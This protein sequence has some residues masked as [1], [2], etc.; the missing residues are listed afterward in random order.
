MDESRVKNADIHIRV[1]PGEKT[2]LQ[3]NAK[4]TGKTL[5][6]YLKNT[7]LEP[8]IDTAKANFY[9]SINADLV[10]LKRATVVLTK[11]TLLAVNSLYQD[12]KELQKE[13]RKAV[14]E[15]EKIFK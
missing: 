11:L 3:I 8:N 15:A 1:T 14:D 6:E 4:I 9:E 13:Y 5:S 2:R 10:Y 7:G 12:Q